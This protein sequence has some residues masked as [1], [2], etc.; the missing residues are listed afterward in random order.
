MR[1]NLALLLLTIGCGPVKLGEER[2]R[3]DAGAAPAGPSDAGAVAVS[4]TVANGGCDGCFQVSAAGSGGNPPYRFEWADGQSGAQR[5]VCPGPDAGA[6][7]VVAQDAQAQSSLPQTLSLD[8]PDASCGGPLLCV[9]N[10]SFE[11][12]PAYNSGPPEVFDCAP[13]STCTNA[14]TGDPD[15]GFNTP[16]V[17]NDTIKQLVVTIPQP[18]NGDTFLG[19]AED[20]QVEQALCQGIAPGTTVFVEIDLRR[21]YIGAGVTPDSEWPFLEIWGGIAA[22]CSQRQLLWASPK[23]SASWKTYC[24]SLQPSQYIDALTLLA[25]TDHSLP[26]PAYMLID[27]MVPVPSCP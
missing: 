5:R 8:F 18:T 3:D 21:L 10:P 12:K 23:L 2:A 13:W 9:E 26:S 17:V 1:G 27:N 4:L 11:G 7:T 19:L 16:D 15:V 6:L 22:D 14:D 24:A 20:E 25:R